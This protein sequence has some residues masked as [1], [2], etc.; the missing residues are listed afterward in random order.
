[1]LKFITFAS[2]LN[3][4]IIAKTSW[5]IHLPER[6]NILNIVTFPKGFFFISDSKKHSFFK[7]FKT[8][9]YFLKYSLANIF[10]LKNRLWKLREPF[11]RKIKSTQTSFTFH[12]KMTTYVLK[13]FRSAWVANGPAVAIASLQLVTFTFQIF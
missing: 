1:M 7:G 8:L 4:H 13:E 12:H 3:T 2:K 9:Q 5:H 11:K 10:K 6:L